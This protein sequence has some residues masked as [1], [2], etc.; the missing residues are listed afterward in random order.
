MPE[1]AQIVPLTW[2]CKIKRLPNGDLDKFK[3]RICVRGDLQKVTEENTYAPVVKWAM[4]RSVLGFAIKHNMKTRQINFANAFV[5]GALPPGKEVYVSLPRGFGNG[6]DSVLKLRKGLYGM[7]QSPLYW[8]TTVKTT[9]KELGYCQSEYD[10]CLFINEKERTIALLY[11]D[12]C[13]C[14]AFD[15]ESLRN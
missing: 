2:V 3:C 6:H 13:L 10:Q 9:F 14:F 5:Q 11:T 7:V 4:I 1:G 12:D 15:D 8:F